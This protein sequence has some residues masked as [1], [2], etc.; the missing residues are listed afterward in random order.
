MGVAKS[1][2]DSASGWVV[3]AEIATL[4]APGAPAAAQ[5]LY[6]FRTAGSAAQIRSDIAA[7]T[8]ALP[9]GAVT[10]TQPYLVVESQE[11]RTISI[12]VPFVVA[13]GVIGLVL[14]V[15]IVANV[16]NGA[17]V[18][19][20]RRIGVLK[21]IGFTP[22]QVVTAYVAQ[23]G[24]PALSGCLIGVAAG[25]L[26]AVPL[27]SQT[28]DVYGVGLLLVPTW[29]DLAVPV[30]MGGLVGLAAL[31]PA[32]R[33]GRLSAVQ[34]IAAG[35]APRPGRGYAAHR[36][37]GRLALPRPVTIGLAAPFARPAR[38]AATIAAIL[39]GA[40]AVI[41][42]TGLASSLDRAAAGESHT[43]T[44]QVQVV[45]PGGDAPARSGQRLTPAGQDRAV[46]AA[47][48]ALPGTARYVAEAMPRVGIAGLAQQAPAEV[49][50][51]DAA[52]TGYNMISGRWFR[53]PGEIDV[54]TALLSQTG[55]SVGDTLVISFGGRLITVRIAGEVFD[56]LGRDQP[57]VLTSW[58]TLGGVRAGLTVQQYDVELR[59]GTNI[60]GY[61]GALSQHLGS[62]F[63]VLVP[64]NDPF[65]N[66]LI[67]LISTLTLLLAV[68]AGLGVLN[69]VAL[70]TRERV[71]ELGVFKA[72]GMTPRQLLEMV[73]CWVAGAG[74]AAGILAIPA[75]LALHASILRVMASAAGTGLPG[76]YVSV[77]R[78]PELL[79]LA[80]SGLV[81]AIAG[82]LL[83]A[84]WAARASTASAL[85][86]E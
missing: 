55:R 63:E 6:T 83:P 1:I 57:A 29:V 62:S 23:A 60:R 18:A 80:L 10:G 13:F 46:A 38:T 43:R 76:S 56:P 67:A 19:G 42:A 85:H 86:A 22:G 44:E 21:S 51:G 36:L 79:V 26:L 16:V 5:L 34:A 70:S 82:A 20:Y 69:T 40:T 17:V 65:Y 58:P 78:A 84:F 31:L 39:F 12:I 64:A 47:V 28:A 73:M 68:V 74:L 50:R 30:A 14:S 27:L 75:G 15:L 8:A 45:L 37:L 7:V 71:H 2:T 11:T 33:A 61:Q 9:A 41:F 72:V 48:A 81:I 35:R 49:F 52:W 53:G 77:F 24:A 3:P 4:R 25:N 54:N 59:P 66:T 32:L